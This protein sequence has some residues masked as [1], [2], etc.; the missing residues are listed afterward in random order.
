[1][2]IIEINSK[3]YYA[4]LSWQTLS[5]ADNVKKRIK[6]FK[7]GFYCVRNLSGMINLG[8]SD[9][10]DGKYKKLTSLASAVA[11]ARKEPW[12]GVFRISDDLYWCI[13]VRDNQAVLPDGD[14][15][16]NK[17]E[18]DKFFR[19]TISI[20]E[21]DSIIESGTVQDIEAIITGKGNY[22]L[23]AS[24]A[25]NLFLALGI[26]IIISSG[27][28]YF[29]H[30]HAEK[31]KIFLP[32]AVF[33]AR[34]PIPGYRTIPEPEFVLDACKKELLNLPQSYYGWQAS[35]LNC[36]PGNISITYIKQDFGT[37]F[38]TPKGIISA[39]GT[40]VSQVIYANFPS[41]AGLRPLLT[42]QGALRMIYGYMQEFNIRGSVKPFGNA[43]RVN[44]D[45]VDLRVL[46]AFFG[47]PSF[48]IKSIQIKGLPLSGNADVSAEVWH[49]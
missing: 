19:E 2:K 47:I 18:A 6:E 14:I 1:M 13:A 23:P 20:G 27:F 30:I 43:I 49:G 26:G 33:V 17:E 12:L 24:R 15:V 35:N 36:T 4:G 9:D 22:V 25:F 28:I 16:G 41:P 21:W 11:N 48:R 39:S 10:S 40:E 8:Y 29:Y 44:M 32:K 3:L 7:K 46:P 31:P 37:A 38:I 42:P 45:N 34:K 5:A